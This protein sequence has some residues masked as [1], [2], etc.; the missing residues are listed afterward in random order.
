MSELIKMPFDDLWQ[1]AATASSCAQVHHRLGPARGLSSPGLSS[2][3]HGDQAAPAAAAAQLQAVARVRAAAA[4]QLQAAS[5]LRHAMMS[6]L[7]PPTDERPLCPQPVSAMVHTRRCH[8][9]MGAGGWPIPPTPVCP[10]H[11]LQL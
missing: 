2:R 3:C 4:A 9:C 8:G 11:S 7:L 1:E 10:R 6:M 5:S